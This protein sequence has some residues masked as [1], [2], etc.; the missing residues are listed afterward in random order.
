M[1]KSFT[2]VG[3]L[4]FGYASW[5]YRRSIVAATPAHETPR[6]PNIL[7][8]AVNDLLMVILGYMGFH[9]FSC[10][11]IFRHRLYVIER[12]NFEKLQG[13]DRENFDLGQE[14]IKPDG[15]KVV[16][17]KLLKEYP[18]AEYVSVSDAD[19]VEEISK[20]QREHIAIQRENLARH[21]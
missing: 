11:Y 4:A 7:G 9:M 12:L 8:K 1:Y 14:T 21:H 18:F 15:S 13:F 5:R 20:E 16:E 10:D 17:N 6:D 19:L 3:A 2:F